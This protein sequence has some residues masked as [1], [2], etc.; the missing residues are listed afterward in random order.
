MMVHRNPPGGVPPGP[1][2][3]AAAGTAVL[4]CMDLSLDALGHLFGFDT[5]PMFMI[6]NAG[7]VATPGALL[8]MSLALGHVERVVVVQHT[9]CTSLPFTDCAQL[10]A[11]ARQG[12]PEPDFQRA[13]GVLQTLRSTVQAIRR[14]PS[15]GSLVEIQGYLYDAGATHLVC[16]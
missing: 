2:H 6:T 16:F 4:T 13:S 10:L 3:E 1:A 8:S 5:G 7:G 12:Q 11:L 9:D 14:F 15:I